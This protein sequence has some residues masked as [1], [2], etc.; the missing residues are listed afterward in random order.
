MAFTQGQTITATELNSVNSGHVYANYSPSTGF[1]GQTYDRKWYSHREAGA[2]LTGDVR[3]SIG[4]FGG[5]ALRLA[6]VDASNNV[7]SW[8]I[9][10]NIVGGIVGASRTYSIKSLGPGWYRLWF[11]ETS[12][13][14]HNSAFRWKLYVSQTD[15]TKGKKLTLYQDP[16]LGGNRLAGEK[17]TVAHLNSGL[18]GTINE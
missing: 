1:Y 14:M 13:P 2:L 15:C 7:I 12:N 11:A 5:V 3:I 9:N 10:E 18:A 16:S 6:R 8:L 17:L 4:A